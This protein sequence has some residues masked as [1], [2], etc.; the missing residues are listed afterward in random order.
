LILVTGATGFLGTHLLQE[1][2]K[3]D[4]PV[5][6]L[7]H[8]NEPNQELREQVQWQ[9]CNLLDTAEIEMAMKGIKYVFHCAAVV[10]FDPRKK[11][12]M[13]ENNVTITANIVNAALNEN[14]HKLL[15]VSSIAAIGRAYPE[16]GSQEK[17]FID[18]KTPWTESKNNSSYAESKYLSELEIWRG[19]AEGLNTAIINPSVILGEGDWDKGSAKLMQVVDQEFPWFTEGIN[20]WVD[21]KDVVNALLLLMNK[22]T[23][24]ERFIINNGNYAYKD[25]FTQM[26]LAL[27]KKPPHKKASKWIIELVWRFELLKSRLARKEATIT[28]ETARTA[29]TQCF[30]NNEKFLKQFPEFQYQSI[31]DTILRMASIYLTMPK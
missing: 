17:I 6:A 18:E 2:R 16:K 3:Q 19:M 23:N 28:K 14:V 26:A 8:K 25:I 12:E 5:R 11:H 24:G 9:Q 21:V 4:M 31:E 29:Q 20:G 15:H 30:Y 7:Y 1:L 13:I 10:S 22:E 27:N